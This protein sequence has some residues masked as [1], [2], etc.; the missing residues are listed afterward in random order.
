MFTI[1]PKNSQIDLSIFDLQALTNKANETAQEIERHNYEVYWKF[2]GLVNDYVG[3]INAYMYK[4][5][6]PDFVNTN[7][8]IKKHYIS[9][10]SGLHVAY[11]FGHGRGRVRISFQTKQVGRKYSYDFQGE[12]R[13]SKN[14]TDKQCKHIECPLESVEQILEVGAQVFQL[15]IIDRDVKDFSQKVILENQL[16]Y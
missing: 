9:T 3:Q 14:W 2:E 12:I 4:L 11:E 5:G 6:L 16:T 15:F 8:H 13:V 10:A 1:K 7:A